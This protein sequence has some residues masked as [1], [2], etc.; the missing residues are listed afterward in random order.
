MAKIIDK[1]TG[2]PEG[3]VCTYQE[4]YTERPKRDFYVPHKR[5]SWVGIDPKTGEI[6]A[7]RTK[8][9]EMDACDIHNI[10]KQYSVQGLQQLIAEN[11]AKGRYADLPDNIDYQESLN[12][13]MEAQRAFAT[14]PAHVRERFN[15]DPAKLLEFMSNPDNQDEAIKLGLATDN[16]PATPPPTKVEI[17][18][19]EPPKAST[20]DKK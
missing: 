13:V 2:E 14:L 5:Y 20:D 1:Q 16:R 12:T 8:Q 18:A 4:R 17:V 7:S 10:L 3:E 6:L 15:N 11:Q 19:G 9:S